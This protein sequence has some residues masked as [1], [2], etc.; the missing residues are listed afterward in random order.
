[1]TG[2]LEA[3]LV[4][5]LQAPREVQRAVTDHAVLCSRCSVPVVLLVHLGRPALIVPD[6]RPAPLPADWNPPPI[7]ADVTGVELLELALVATGMSWQDRHRNRSQG[8]WSKPLEV[9]DEHP[10]L[11]VVC[12]CRMWRLPTQWLR[13]RFA[14]TT[15]SATKL[16]PDQPPE[17]DT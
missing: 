5:Y 6:H 8:F 3:H 1:M 16:R 17:V 7:P 9:L 14:D 11:R 10:A 12:D 2:D 13:A 15:A 4:Q